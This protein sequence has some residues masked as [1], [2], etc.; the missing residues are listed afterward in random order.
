[1]DELHVVAGKLKAGKV[2]FDICRLDHTLEDGSFRLDIYPEDAICSCAQLVTHDN[3]NTMRSTT[4]ADLPAGRYRLTIA[5]YMDK[6][7][8]DTAMK[9]VTDF[10]TIEVQE[11]D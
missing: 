4:W 8:G 10:A 3:D 11:A 9:W 7:D 2:F 6:W 5:K 1:M